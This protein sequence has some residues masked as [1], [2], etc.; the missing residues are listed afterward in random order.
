MP[1]EGIFF[2]VINVFSLSSFISETTFPKA[3]VIKGD[4]F[5]LASLE[6]AMR[7]Q[8]VVY[9][10]L[11]VAQSSKKNDPQPEREGITN[12]IA[13]ARKTGVKRIAYLSS[14]I[15]NYQGMNGFKWWAFDI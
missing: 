6:A 15:K 1:L 4:V 12:I 13:A 11:S 7:G 2:R 9:L 5:D 10:N 3:S 8:E 14:L